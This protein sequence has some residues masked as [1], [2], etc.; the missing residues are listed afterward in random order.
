MPKNNRAGQAA[1]LSEAD[2]L[3]IRRQLCNREH[4]LFFDVARFTGERWGA[5]C[6]LHVDDV[7]RDPHCSR[8]HEDITFRAAT[9]KASPDG[10]RYTRQ[11]PLHPSLK[12]ILE[13]YKPPHD[14]WLFPS[15]SRP[16]SHLS[17]QGADDFFRRA[18]ERAGINDKGIS[19]HSTRRTF[20]TLLYL[21]GVDLSTLQKI[22][23]HHDLKSL[24]RYIEISPDRV[25]R[26][27]AVL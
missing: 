22:T 3:K 13:A 12:E 8:P 19:S 4:R 27:I 2:I 15:R 11:V 20:I 25:R 9:R 1:I 24:Q 10:S 26:A 7:Y 6:Q 17:F 5:I 14:G 23:G 18:L 16:G 21:K